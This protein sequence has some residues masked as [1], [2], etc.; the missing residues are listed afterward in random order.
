MT[1]RKLSE[2][3][4]QHPL[5]L[6]LS[7]GGFCPKD[8]WQAEGLVELHREMEIG[9]CR[10][11]TISTDNIT[12]TNEYRSGVGAHWPFLSDAGRKVQKA[13]DIDMHTKDARAAGETEQRLYGLSAWREAPFYTERE[14]AGLAWAEV[15]TDISE[16]HA[17]DEEYEAARAQFDE[18]ELVKLTMAIIAINGWNRLSIAFRPEVGSY[19]PRGKA[20]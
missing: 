17:S 9:Y 19:Q 10:L 12:E 14:R 15:I 2:L 3:Q 11:V 13:H 18:G 7:R 20:E 16:T 8:Q 5:V 6:V 1:R 4:G